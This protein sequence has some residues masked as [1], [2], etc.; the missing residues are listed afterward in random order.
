MEPTKIDRLFAAKAV[1]K[2]A[3]KRVSELE[4]ECKEELLEEYSTTGNDRKRSPMFGNEAGYLVIEQH[5]KKR[6]VRE[7]VAD[8]GKVNAW[9]R[10]AKPDYEEFAKDNLDVFCSWWLKTTGE[11]IPGFERIE[12]VTPAT[13]IPKLTVKEKVV[14]PML[15][16]ANILEGVGRYLLGDGE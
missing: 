7:Y 16:E 8:H 4:A 14:I 5:E 13:Y 12:I 6:E 3:Q 11:A 10:E 2:E 9:L 15:R 1:L